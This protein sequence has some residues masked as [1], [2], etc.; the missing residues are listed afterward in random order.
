MRLKEMRGN[1]KEHLTG[2]FC[3]LTWENSTLEELEETSGNRR[4]RFPPE[5]G[6]SD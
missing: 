2:R 6:G 3:P 4:V 1:V 5:T